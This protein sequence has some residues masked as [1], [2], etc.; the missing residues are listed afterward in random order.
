MLRGGKSRPRN[1][2]ILNML[3]YIGVGER[4]GSGVPNIYAIWEQEGYVD[5]TVEELS[6][7]EDTI[8]TVVTLPLVKKDRSRDQSLSEKGTEKGTDQRV[9]KSA[10]ISERVEKVLQ[11]IIDNPTIS[12]TQIADQLGIS[13]KQAQNATELLK[14]NNRIHR[15]GSARNGKWIID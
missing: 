5:P 4:A 3:N 9:K 6:G 2:V 8:D 11:L 1:I 7:R 15:E 14:Q 10:E 12:Q 13:I